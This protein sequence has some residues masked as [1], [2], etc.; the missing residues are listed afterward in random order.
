MQNVR[1]TDTSFY[2]DNNNNGR[3]AKKKGGEKDIMI[4]RVLQIKN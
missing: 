3:I 2:T 4:I 1:A